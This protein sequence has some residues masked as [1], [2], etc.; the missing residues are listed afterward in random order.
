MKNG[1]FIVI[2]DHCFFTGQ[3]INQVDENEVIPRKVS[4]AVV[5]TISTVAAVLNY[6]KSKLFLSLTWHLDKAAV[7]YPS[8][9]T[10]HAIL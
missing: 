5:T 6:P 9:L 10:L 7:R 4:E 3:P 2:C 1:K 8:F